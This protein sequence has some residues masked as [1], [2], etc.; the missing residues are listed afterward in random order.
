M[1]RELLCSCQPYWLKKPLLFHLLPWNPTL[2]CFVFVLLP[3]VTFCLFERCL[4][5]SFPP[6]YVSSTSTV[7]PRNL[8]VLTWV[9]VSDSL[10]HEPSRRLSNIQMFGQLW[11][12]NPLW[13]CCFKID[14]KKPLGEFL[15]LGIAKY[16]S[17]D[18]SEYLATFRTFIADIIRIMIYFFGASTTWT[19]FSFCP[20]LVF[21]MLQAFFR[22]VKV[23]GKFQKFHFSGPILITGYDAVFIFG[24]PS[25]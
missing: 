10:E 24:S 17:S 11:A 14:C 16:C 3:C 2:V 4:F 5:F 1:P 25:V 8:S 7:P 15:Y 9:N 13:V 19:I 18:D 6:T 12:G 22:S 21:D 23:F 20:S